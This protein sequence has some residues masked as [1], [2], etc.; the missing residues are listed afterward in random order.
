MSDFSS[1]I[2]KYKENVIPKN[3]NDKNNYYNKYLKYKNKYLE[4][5]QLAGSGFSDET[6]L[7]IEPIQAVRIKANRDLHYKIKMEKKEPIHHIL[8]YDLINKELTLKQLRENKLFY[9]WMHGAIIENDDIILKPGQRIISL[10]YFALYYE[11]PY[12]V[13]NFILKFFRE[14]PEFD[15]LTFLSQL[16][17]VKIGDQKLDD[18]FN[19]KYGIYDGN[20]SEARTL[21]NISFTPFEQYDIRAYLSK[22]IY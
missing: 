22:I 14:W 12:V 15:K 5:K 11:L 8:N 16:G 7:E 2:N 20:I 3:L 19:R 10:K 4:L 9:T 17:G 13:H 18:I 6:K 1:I 21:P